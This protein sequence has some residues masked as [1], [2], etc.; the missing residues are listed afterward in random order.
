MP[1]TLDVA[2][3]QQFIG[4]SEQQMIKVYF[5]GILPDRCFPTDF[6]IM[7]YELFLDDISEEVPDVEIPD[8]IV[9]DDISEEVPDVEG[10][11]FK[12]LLA[13]FRNEKM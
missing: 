12:I 4:G 11:F 5:S 6:L 8:E 10:T 1:R 2:D 13:R 3:E 9:L 7:M